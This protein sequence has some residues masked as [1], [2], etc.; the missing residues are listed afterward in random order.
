M[1]LQENIE[2]IGYFKYETS[3]KTFSSLCNEYPITEEIIKHLKKSNH[4]KLELDKNN[5]RLVNGKF[6]VLI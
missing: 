6:V 2:K 1:N 3:N 5:F 4:I